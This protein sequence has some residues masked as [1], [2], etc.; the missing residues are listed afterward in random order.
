[1]QRA[2][3]R[4][5]STQELLL[6]TFLKDESSPMSKPRTTRAKLPLVIKRKK[7]TPISVNITHS[8]LLR[9]TKNLEEAIALIGLIISLIKMDRFRASL[10]K[11]IE[12]KIRALLRAIFHIATLNLRLLHFRI[13]IIFEWLLLR[14]LRWNRLRDHKKFKIWLVLFLTKMVWKLN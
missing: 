13:L 7:K 8:A 12:A 11:R 6:P 3:Q 10:N 5:N 4:E 9:N 1:M 2:I 14:P